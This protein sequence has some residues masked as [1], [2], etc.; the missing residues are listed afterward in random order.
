MVNT[1]FIVNTVP[2]KVEENIKWMKLEE[3][4]LAFVTLSTNIRYDLLPMAP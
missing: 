1:Q 3:T 2:V 4:S